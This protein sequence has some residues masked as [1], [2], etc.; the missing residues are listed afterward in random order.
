MITAFFLVLALFTASLGLKK[1]WPNLC[2]IC[3]SVSLTWIA[4]ILAGYLGYYVSPIVLAALLGASAVGG[5]YYLSHKLG[6]TF[7]F[8]KLPYLLT[9]IYVIYVYLEERFQLLELLMVISL[10]TVFLFIWLSKS[11]SAKNLTSKLI[12][13]C[14]NW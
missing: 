1:K 9:S 7:E 14:R 5:M 6:S 2:A 13:C 8:W 12:E 10:W 3:N 11:K 4:L